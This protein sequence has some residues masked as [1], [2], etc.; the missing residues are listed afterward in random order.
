MMNT[1]LLFVSCISAVVA[2]MLLVWFSKDLHHNKIVLLA[3][4]IIINLATF[5]WTYTM[6]KGIESATAI[7]CYALFTVVGCSFLGIVVFKESISTVNAFGMGLGLL[8][9]ILVSIPK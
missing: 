7:T 9:L 1:V 2:D 6:Y 5:L 3:G 8:S 4:V